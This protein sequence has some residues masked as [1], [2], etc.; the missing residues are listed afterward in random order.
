M[1]GECCGD[2]AVVRL[3]AVGQGSN[4]ADGEW[5][6][7]HFCRNPRC[8]IYFFVPIVRVAC[9]APIVRVAHGWGGGVAA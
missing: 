1:S 6:A 7:V 2:V 4:P 9:D 3:V 5:V 8:H